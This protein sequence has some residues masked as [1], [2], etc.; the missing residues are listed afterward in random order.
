M[1]ISNFLRDKL[2]FILTV[3]FTAG[4]CDLIFYI[5]NLP[6][7]IAILLTSMYLIGSFAA[8]MW[9]FFTKKSYFN[10][11]KCTLDGLE[12]KCYISEVMDKPS[13]IEGRIMDEVLSILCKSMNDEI[14][15]EHMKGREYR[16]YIELWV[17]EIKTP[18]SAAMLTCENNGYTYVLHELHRIDRYVEQALFYARSSS[19]EK[20]YII[21]QIDLKKLIGDLLKKNASFLIS[22]KIKVI[23]K[24]EGKVYSDSKWLMFILQQLI[25][26][27][28]KYNAKTLYFTYIDR[29]LTVEDDG[30]GI[31]PQDLP[32]IFDRGFT[33]ENGRINAKSTGMG[34]YLC[35]ELCKKLGL[36]ISASSQNGVEFSIVFPEN[37]YVTFS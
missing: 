35:K 26:N 31:Q 14:S 32:R 18:I 28:V 6:A 22:N 11:L 21:K 24:T 33:G 17:H 25:D 2:Y 12:K 15:I 36:K 8:L 13:F 34:L 10:E 1:T 27:A 16:E 4:M 5:F 30:I 19:V 7:A 3:L 23:P 9:E 20:D 29:T 37:P